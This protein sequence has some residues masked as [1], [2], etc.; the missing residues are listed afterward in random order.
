M[1][2]VMGASGYVGNYVIKN[3]LEMTDDLV[4]ATSRCDEKRVT[5]NCRVEW[6][7]IN[8]INSAQIALLNA[9]TKSMSNLKVIYLIGV[10]SPDKVQQN[11]QDAWDIDII[12]LANF[13]NIMENM[14]VFWYASS[15]AVFSGGSRG[16][17]FM[18][19]DPLCPMNLYGRHKAAAE[20]LVTAKGF[21]SVR[22]PVMIGKSLSPHRK[23]FF[24]EI[25]DKLLRGEKIA[26]FSDMVRSIIDV[27]TAA[28]A[29]VSLVEN[30][31][32][33]KYPAI[34]ISG[35]EALS[36][37]EI[38]LRIAHKYGFSKEQ[39]LPVKM[40]DEKIFKEKREHTHLL[41]N[42]LLKKLLEI[43][44]LEAQI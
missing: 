25:T 10:A 36:K 26:M 15:E 16:Y 5:D 7:T 22:F 11:P 35:D 20:F 33:H 2:L 9:R 19:N 4:L 21:N 44:A 28:K 13:L 14:T 17:K 38:G 12:A 41:D 23:A 31:E 37:Y 3:I 1:Y 6:L 43:E 30:N 42:T 29:L 39:I 8:I 24:D 18:D 40:N 34:N 27:D 32:A